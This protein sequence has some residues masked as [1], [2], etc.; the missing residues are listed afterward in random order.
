[1]NEPLLEITGLHKRFGH[2]E[3][4]HDVSLR[5]E[6]GEVHAVLGENG[7]GKT[8]LMN[9]LYGLVAADRG[10]LRLDGEDIAPRSPAA[11]RALGIGMI[12]QHFMLVPTFTGLENAVLGHPRFRPSGPRLELARQEAAA[13]RA[14]LRLDVDLERPVADLSVGQQQ[15]V[16][17]LKTLLRECRLLVL[18]EPTAVLTPGEVNDLFS[19]LRA[20][21]AEGRSII[22]ISHKLEEVKA[23]S[24]RI[25]VLRAG[26]VS[27]R[28]VTVAADVASLARAVSPDAV[29][30]PATAKTPVGNDVILRAHRLRVCRDDG[31]LALDDVGFEVHAGEI[32][33]VAGVD[34]NGQAELSAALIGLLRLAGGRLEMRGVEISAWSA[35]ARYLGGLALVPGDRRGMGIFPGLS[36]WQNMTVVVHREKDFQR[37]GLLRTGALRQWASAI[38][39]RF[40]VRGG[41]VLAP[42]ETLSGGNQQKLLV[43]RE[44]ARLPSLLIA[45]NPTRGVDLAATRRIHDA[46]GEQ[47]ERGGGVLLISTELN[48]VLALADSVYVMVSGALLGPYPA[49]TPV[50][51][52]GT[53]MLG[54]SLP[55]PESAQPKR[56]PGAREV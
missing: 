52:L 28:F 23:I 19:L 30:Q 33:G 48:E 20:L 24:D 42:V 5:V 37:G 13:L 43:A 55:A 14:R 32:V 49:T 41:G 27:G 29:E 12:H 45:V 16:E 53:L 26:R 44:Q 36:L 21:R 8:T 7:A 4:L 6:R 22:F 47:R 56:P 11:A 15:R 38:I 54:S 18:D 39:T 46:L 51:N 17:I 2:V 25:T 1:M 3:A 9:I 34:G 31:T 40:D 35:A 50:E 10:S